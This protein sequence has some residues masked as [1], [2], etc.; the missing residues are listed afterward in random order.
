MTSSSSLA[1]LASSA[2]STVF[3]KLSH[4]SSSFET[5]PTG[6]GGGGGGF[7]PPRTS[8]KPPPQFTSPPFGFDPP[9][10]SSTSTTSSSL[11]ALATNSGLLSATTSPQVSAVSG[12]SQNA[13]PLGLIIGASVGGMVL[14]ALIAFLLFF[15]RRRRAQRRAHHGQGL[16]A[17][18][19]NQDP[20]KAAI[21]VPLVKP[22]SIPSPNTKVTD[23]M[24]RNNRAV[25]VST[26]SSF[27]SPTVIETA[28]VGTRTSI[29]AYSQ[30]SAIPSGMSADLNK[31]EEGGLP[32][33]PG[34][35]RITE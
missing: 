3:L 34:L 27:S 31:P 30:A 24:Q 32:R 18:T 9:P 28:S 8:S 11:S 25:S 7:Q 12:S 2:E 10:F 16:V 23:W 17:Y 29:S 20:E 6:G 13:L 15:F 19:P 35:Y 22:S 21:T 14:G 4:S 1:L 26:I 33:P 5:G